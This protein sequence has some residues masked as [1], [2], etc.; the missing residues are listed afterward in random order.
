M[1]RSEAYRTPP[2]LEGQRLDRAL[3]Q[4][5]G[6]SRGWARQVI[7]LGGVYLDRK[8]VRKQSR[9][10]G[11][12]QR[13]QACWVEPPEALPPPLPQQA[14]LLRRHGLVAVNKPAGVH[15]QAARHRVAGTLP[16][17]VRALLGIASAPDPIHRLDRDCSGIVVL[18]ET[19]RARSGLG[20]LWRTGGASKR[21]LAL[22]AGQPPEEE[23]EIDAPLARE[24]GSAFVSEQGKASLTRLRLLD[25]AGATSLAELEPVTGRT[26][27]LRVH[28]AHI[29]CP[30]LGDQR[31]AHAQARE[32]ASQ[33]CLHAWRLSLPPGFPGTPCKLQAPLP[34]RFAQRLEALGMRLPGC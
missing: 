8:R 30:I 28:C 33:L 29:G 16:E 7:A 23:L 26:H 22:L 31:Y 17:L 25:R 4:L 20:A 34:E 11:A 15:C 27:Q 3:A 19:R 10:L 13:L 18:G 5:S 2:E 24:R 9:S 14:L 6:R 1:L 32:A 21:Y 12:G